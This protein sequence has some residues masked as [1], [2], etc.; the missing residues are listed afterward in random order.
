MRG[1]V[2]KQ[3]L[4]LDLEPVQDPVRMPEPRLDLER[5]P[6]LAHKQELGLESPGLETKV[7]QSKVD[8]MLRE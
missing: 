1:L 4:G 7:Q 2:H 5:V 8:S 6:A 3:E